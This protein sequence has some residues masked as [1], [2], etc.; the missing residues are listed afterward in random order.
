MTYILLVTILAAF[1]VYFYK[2]SSF[3]DLIARKRISQA[4]QNAELIKVLFDL[5]EEPLDDLFRLYQEQFGDNAARYARHTF[6]KWKAGEVRP[7]RQT[8]NRFLLH[9]PKVM[10]F[11]LKCEV[12]RELR[13]AYCARDNYE[14]TVHTDDWKETLTPLVQSII[15]KANDAELPQQVLKRLYWLAGDDMQIAREILAR[16]QTQQ[17]LNALSLLDKE[18]SSIERL[19][20]SAKGT[21]RVT[22]VLGLP[23]GTITLKI[24]GRSNN[25]R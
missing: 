23:L 1:L 9:L 13:E 21:G 17:T 25:G 11:D 19:L 2:N 7:N 10:S 16:S 22:H 24:E 20:D 6:R 12:L 3:P 15:T 8:F 5:E 14:L 18:F 4:A